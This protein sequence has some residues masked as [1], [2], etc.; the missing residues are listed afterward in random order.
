LAVGEPAI[1]RVAVVKPLRGQS[2]T[3]VVTAVARALYRN[4][5]GP[6]ILDDDLAL[7]LAGEEGAALAVRFRTE[8]PRLHVL[9]FCRWMCIRS[10]FTED[11]VER[12][13]GRGVGQYVILGAGLDSFAF[14]RGD[15]MGRLRVFEVDHPASQS[16]KQDRL[17]DL[18]I[19][20]PGN[21]VFAAV[22]FERQTLREGLVSAGFDFT[23]AA[24]F[25]WIGVTMYLTGDAIEATLGTISQC[26][27]GS[28]VA[29]TYNQPHRVL[30][31][32]SLQVTSTFEAIATELGEPF[33]S[34]FVPD[35]IEGLLR[36]HGFD[37]IVHFGPQEARAAWFGGAV[38]VAIAGAQRLIAATVSPIAHAAVVSR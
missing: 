15:L 29:L 21:L 23:R 5:P 33:V 31:D 2:R 3:A 27:P 24:V 32:S 16:W 25:S 6:V 20:I 22:D 30:D 8:L 18:G 10:R 34:L 4:E 36:N 38:D 28:Q 19:E 14:R 35:E 12:A 13:I 17:C 9:A 37:D 7:G 11:L 1:Y 26:M